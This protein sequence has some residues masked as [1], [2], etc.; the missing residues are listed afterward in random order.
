MV[1]I[2]VL[3]ICFLSSVAVFGNATETDPSDTESSETTTTVTTTTTTVS[4]TQTTV[5]TTKTTTKATTAST[6]KPTTKPTAATTKPTSST[7]TTAPTEPSE[8][9]TPDNSD[10]PT[11]DLTEDDLQYLQDLQSQRAELQKQASALEEVRRQYSNTLDGLLQQKANIEAQIGIKQQEIDINAQIRDRIKTR[12]QINDLTM[13]RQEQSYLERREALLIRFESL[14]TRVRALA[15]TNEITSLLLLAGADTYSEYLINLKFSERLVFKDQEALR[16][17]ESE[18]TAIMNERRVL[19]NAQQ[20]LR[21]ELEPYTSAERSLSY[22]KR[23]LLAL[24]T[25]ASKIQEQ[26]STQIAY[27]R[28]QTQMINEQQSSLKLQI[29]DILK[30]YNSTDLIAPP[31]MSWPAPDCSIITSS[32]KPR[33]ERWHHGIDI[34][35]WG[36]STGKPIVAAADGIVIFAGTDDSGF[37][38]YVIIDHGY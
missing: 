36:N 9:T 6:A 35:S 25:E 15:K 20:A 24:H 1:Q 5:T 33:W 12:I 3:M 16:E 29:A 38:N 17:L 14:Q 21:A 11:N 2:I 7:S 18:L 4:T 32:F 8:P 13:L 28:E 19:E 26:L 23:E 31:V 27:Y 37:G 34:A 30:N 10:S 22:T